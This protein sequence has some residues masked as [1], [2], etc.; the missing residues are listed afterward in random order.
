MQNALDEY[1]KHED[2]T[3]VSENNTIEADI[4]SATT[5]V[6][7]SVTEISLTT[8]TVPVT[9]VPVTTVTSAVT[10]TSA[11]TATSVPATIAVL[12]ETSAVTQ[13]EKAAAVTEPPAP[14]TEPQ[15]QA[16]SDPPSPPSADPPGLQ[17]PSGITANESSKADVSYLKNC[18]FVGD[19]HIERLK[20]TKYASEGNIDKNKVLSVV[21]LGINK[22]AETI[23]VSSV[24]AVDPENIYIMI[25]T[26][27]VN[28][29]F[30]SL[31]KMY[32]EYVNS[33]EREIPG[34]DIYI[35]SIPPIGKAYEERTV[36]QI[37]NSTIDGFNDRLQKMANEN[38][39]HFLNF[40]PLLHSS[41]GYLDYT[42]DGLHVRP[43]NYDIIIDY[44]LTHTDK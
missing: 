26:N 14:V 41:D 35:M 44:I 22:L 27:S 30:D 8:T 29:N 34:A 3:A 19:S 32:S 40:H 20:L 24:K 37:L 36:G 21:G 33:L 6:T 28:S 13:T 18:A 38:G 39:W 17:H 5:S 4:T 15:A 23:P 42:N 16:P 43:E 2:E 1:K 25:G 11:L 12:T 9:T 31:I 10:T 7:V